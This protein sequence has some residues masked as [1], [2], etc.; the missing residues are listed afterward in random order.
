ML[1]AHHQILSEDKVYNY[2]QENGRMPDTHV[3]G[4]DAIGKEIKNQQDSQNSSF[5]RIRAEKNTQEIIEKSKQ[6]TLNKIRNSTRP[7]TFIFDGHGSEDALFLT[8][9]EVS[10]QT[11]KIQ[12]KENSIR[13][14]PKELA[15]AL[16]QGNKNNQEAYNNPNKRDIIIFAQCLN[17]SFIRKVYEVIGNKAPL[18]ISINGSEYGQLMYSDFRSKYGAALFE[19]ILFA[20]D[21]SSIGSV[22]ENHDSGSS[23]LSI[24][25]GGDQSSL[26]QIR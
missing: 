26:L 7:F 12:E 23:N 11:G 8:D 13:I 25:T 5:E 6:N 14:T 20:S 18:P 22:L 17:H 19:R 16:I 10:E 4:R 1:T 15:E 24:Y 2:E 9:G 3:F 21:K